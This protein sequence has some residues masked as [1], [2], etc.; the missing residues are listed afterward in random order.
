MLLA[1]TSVTNESVNIDDVLKVVINYA[2]DKVVKVFKY[3]K[4]FSGKLGCYNE[5]KIQLEKKEGKILK[6]S[7]PHMVIRAC[8]DVFERELQR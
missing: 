1:S 4:L 3:S 8:Y 2:H 6:H 7:R 5:N